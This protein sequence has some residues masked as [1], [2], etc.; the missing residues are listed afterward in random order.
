[1]LS[2]GKDGRIGEKQGEKRG[3]N[4][5]EQILTLCIFILFIFNGEGTASF[6]VIRE[7]GFEHFELLLLLV[8]FVLMHK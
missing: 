5:G 6:V 2:A 4:R 1:M 7:D 3:E 8:F